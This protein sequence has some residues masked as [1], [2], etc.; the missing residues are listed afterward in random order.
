MTTPRLQGLFAI[1]ASLLFAITP[2]ASEPQPS[3]QGKTLSLWL[4]IWEESNAGR[5]VTQ[6]KEAE[7]AIRSMDG[8]A[9]V[10]LAKLI[11]MWDPRLDDNRFF[12]AVNH[13]FVILGD[14]GKDAVPVLLRGLNQF[15]KNLQES[16]EKLRFLIA[17]LAWVA[18]GPEAARALLR[19]PLLKGG[20]REI[21]H[22]ELALTGILNKGDQETRAVVR[23]SRIR[24]FGLPCFAIQL[25]WCILPP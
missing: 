9:A 14:N 19:V 25:S 23:R 7:G 24:D 17:N 4:Q 11:E 8:A 10:Y 22:L 3:Y 2:S 20:D 21:H 12:R 15:G 5:N 1:I 13:A 18:N 6:E 16:S